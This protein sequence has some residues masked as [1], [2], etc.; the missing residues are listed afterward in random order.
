M[1]PKLMTVKLPV[2]LSSRKLS[3]GREF[4]H[5]LCGWTSKNRMVAE[6]RSDGDTNWHRRL[7]HYGRGRSTNEVVRPFSRES[8]FQ[9]NGRTAPSEGRHQTIW[10]ASCDTT[11]VST[12]KCYSARCRYPCR[13][14][15]PDFGRPRQSCER[16][17]VLCICR[18]AT[19]VHHYSCIRIC[20]LNLK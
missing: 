20:V 19:S 2:R 11:R 18:E 13:C 1:G 3:E 4:I 7:G 8:G 16:V 5:S 9:L 14:H 15:L 10:R 17:K 12:T 6:S